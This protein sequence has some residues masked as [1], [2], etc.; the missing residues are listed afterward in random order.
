MNA[1]EN[2]AQSRHSLKD[3]N[4]KGGQVLNAA[5]EDSLSMCCLPTAQEG[6]RVQENISGESGKMSLGRRKKKD[7]GGSE[8][9]GIPYGVLLKSATDH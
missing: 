3:P 8:L 9:P 4:S 2:T 7:R 1:L 5:E 6:M